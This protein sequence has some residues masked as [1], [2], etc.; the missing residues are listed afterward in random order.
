MLRRFL[1]VCAIV[2]L[3]AIPGAA[4]AS[5]AS[6]RL[7]ST[8]SGLQQA[9]P[10]VGR[11]LGD[12]YRAG[13]GDMVQPASGGLLV[14]RQATATPAFT[15]GYRTWT[16]GPQGLQ[17]RLNSR[18]FSWE[19]RANTGLVLGASAMIASPT[20]RVLSTTIGAT[21]GPLRFQVA[22]SG[23]QPGERVTLQGTYTPLVAGPEPHT[24]WTLPLGPV[25]VHADSG[26]AFTASI[27]TSNPHTGVNYFL[28]ATG[29][30]S[31]PSNLALSVVSAT[32]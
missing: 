4:Q 31:G 1:G 12:S 27:E 29:E 24:C 18:R 14:F 20:L 23:F 32:C 5:G 30:H 17:E 26:G 19:E 6:C 11:C 2:G 22:G 25:T 15:D 7:A 8:F 3:L 16:I 9:V 21:A 13:N 28:R 10:A